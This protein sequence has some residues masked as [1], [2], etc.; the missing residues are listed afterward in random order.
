MYDPNV[1]G[2]D[3]DK[4]VAGEEYL[5]SLL[6]AKVCGQPSF[7]IVKEIVIT[8]ENNARANWDAA[9][10]PMLGQKLS[11]DLMRAFIPAKLHFQSRY[12]LDAGD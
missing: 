6:Y 2:L 9:L 11:G 5:R 7:E 4:S 12:D 1:W 10:V 8:F 3:A